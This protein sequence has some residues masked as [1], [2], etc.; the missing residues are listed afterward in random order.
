[1]IPT[2]HFRGALPAQLLFPSPAALRQGYLRV[3]RMQENLHEHP[4][5]QVELLRQPGVVLLGL[6]YL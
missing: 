4:G 5:R 6:I 2:Q 3:P 1:M